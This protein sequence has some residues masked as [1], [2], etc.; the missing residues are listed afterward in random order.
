MG[1]KYDIKYNNGETFVEHQEFSDLFQ[2]SL[3]ELIDNEV[4]SGNYKRA[5][6]W[7]I[8]Y[9]KITTHEV[10][11]KYLMGACKF[12]DMDKATARTLW[13]EADKELATITS[14]D[15]WSEADKKM[16]KSGVLY[17]AAAMIKGRQNDS[18]RALLNKVAQ[19][20]E[21]DED[22]KSRYDAVVN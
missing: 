20:F 13:Q 10:G 4:V 16:L 22:W 15:G 9:Q 14:L 12:E 6:G 5:Y 7:A 19:W 8:K 1:L 11:A 17:S 2:L 18:A 21:E 3:Q